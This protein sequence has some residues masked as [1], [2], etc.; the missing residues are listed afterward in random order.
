MTVNVPT[1]PAGPSATRDQRDDRGETSLAVGRYTLHGVLAQ[2]GMAT[3]HFGRLIG[4]ADFTR[5]VAVKRLHPQFAGEPDFVAM[6]LDEARLAARIQHPNVVA[7]LDVTEASG[8]LLVVFEY[9]HGESLSKLLALSRKGTPPPIAVVSAIVAELLHGLHAA[10]EATGPEGEPLGIV[11]R[12][13]SP[14]NVLVGADGV[15][16]LIDF[17]VAK[18]RARL[19][20]TREGEIKGKLAYM[21]PEQL[22][23]HSA[24]PQSDVYAAGVVLWEALTGRRLFAADNEGAVVE[25]VLIGLVD[26][27]SNFLPEI[28]EALDAVAL[29]AVDRDPAERFSTA[30]AMAEA[31]ESAL[32]PASS[33]EVAAWVNATALEMLTRRADQ[34]ACIERNEA[35]SSDALG[36]AFLARLT[37]SNAAEPLLIEAA[38]ARI[39]SEPALVELEPAIGATAAQQVAP[40]SPRR[41]RARA[42]A[43]ALGALACGALALGVLVLARSPGTAAAEAS[44]LTREPSPSATGA[45]PTATLLP[46]I[47]APPPAASAVAVPS[48]AVV[49][50]SSATRHALSTR[51]PARPPVAR[52]DCK[53]PYTLDSTGRKNY[54]RECL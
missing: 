51:P 12:D 31:L 15:T 17:G 3:V 32:P 6:F 30:R 53:I 41:H 42:G 36:R 24:T 21:A 22:R 2:G 5:I 44:A 40:A 4:A 14:Q 20:T 29:R 52:P 50:G 9:V 43:L 18:A 7:P 26:A 49:T 13:V 46:S 45:Q 37:T 25:R 28:S 19:Q 8:E 48:T 38:P 27:P 1:S 11:H 54:K 33:A 47:E 23:G 16:R 10:H 35:P 39:E 34:V